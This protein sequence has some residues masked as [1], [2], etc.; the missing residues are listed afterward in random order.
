MEAVV[1]NKFKEQHAYGDRNNLNLLNGKYAI[2][3]Y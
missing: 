2:L 3:L 1:I